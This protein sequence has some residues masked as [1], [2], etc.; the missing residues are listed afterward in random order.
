MTEVLSL[1]GTDRRSGLRDVSAWEHD[2]D[3][4][5]VIEELVSSILDG[6]IKSREELQKEKLLAAKKRTLG[7]LPTNSMILDM[8]RKRHPEREDELLWLL[9]KK[10]SRTVSGVAVVAVMT[11]PHSCPHGKCIFCPGG[12]EKEVPT[13]QS[14]TGREPAAM[15]GADNDYDPLKQV[16]RRIEQLEMV[17]HSTDKIDLILMG[18][19]VTARSPE[20]Q[21]EFVK[22]CLDG[23]NG[24]ISTTLGEA[25]DLNE[26]SEHRCIG[27]TFETRPDHFGDEESDL[28]L[29][30]GG[31][32]LELGVQ[33]LFDLPLLRSE[34][35]HSVMDTVNATKT[36][37]D[38]GLKVGYH[39]MP[40]IPGS[41]REMNFETAYNAFH[42]SR[43]MPDMI[44]IYPTLVIK[45]TKL[46]DMWKR[47]EY[48]PIQTE[49]A[50]RLVAEIKRITPPWVRIQRVQRDIPSPLVEGGVD[51]SNLR[52][53]AE[54]VMREHGWNCRCIRCREI[55]HR[56]RDGKKPLPENISLSRRE[57]E[58]SGGK[59][60]FLSFEEESTDTLIG[61][62]RL[63]RPSEDAQ[64]REMALS[65]IIRELKVFGQ[66]V[67]IGRD[68]G[69]DWQH[70]GYGSE[71]IKY[72]ESLVKDEWGLDRIL[73]T[74][75]IGVREY[76]RKFGFER[77]G[78]YMGKRL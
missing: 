43:F 42:D 28:M 71:L 76:Y 20:Y 57:Y 67:P 26:S 65:A 17:G 70:R 36:A 52:Q 63:R 74:S 24:T 18:G 27:I 78:P 40:G 21:M 25:Q 68:A 73:V 15:R 46:Y 23:M 3:L 60:V 16:R 5:R 49:D 50:A 75:G 10:P 33:S 44:K 22:G 7:G 59:E 11:S 58:A 45:G 2:P 37:K 39:L 8:I 66:M 13:P 51:K 41:T 55:G 1:E 4:R 54:D 6:S 62:I 14:Y 56:M 72:A 69:D 61:Y 47:G 35:G 64:R 32:R 38:S 30:L 48:E 77:V 12:T 9:V 19:T 31:T 29:S 34:R 53:L